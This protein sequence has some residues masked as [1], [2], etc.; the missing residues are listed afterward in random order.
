MRRLADAQ[1]IERFM[2]EL[3]RAAR[4]TRRTWPTFRAWS[5]TGWSSSNACSTCSTRSSQI[6]IATQQS[7]QRL[8]DR[9]L[10]P[11]WKPRDAARDKRLS[12]C[13]TP[14]RTTRATRTAPRA[15]ARS[16]IGICDMVIRMSGDAFCS[17]SLDAF[18]SMPVRETVRE[19]SE[20][21][22]LTAVRSPQPP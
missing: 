14:P 17:C 3:G 2:K 5:T 13:T 9:P 1:R 19:S 21:G 6:F 12:A 11:T 8:F 7:T 18:S 22:E 15:R 4:A 20:A 10:S 16:G